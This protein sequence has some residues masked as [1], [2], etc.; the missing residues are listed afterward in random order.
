[1]YLMSRSRFDSISG[2]Q[3]QQLFEPK[4][5]TNINPSPSGTSSR[6][7]CFEVQGPGICDA[8]ATRTTTLRNLSI[9]QENCDFTT[10]NG[11]LMVNNGE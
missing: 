4:C 1:M 9:K 5:A 3:E 6:A 11:D 8:Q 2:R 10:I 7:T